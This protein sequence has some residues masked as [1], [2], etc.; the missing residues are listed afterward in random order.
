MALDPY[1]NASYQTN[2]YA[3]A[4]TNRDLIQKVLAEKQMK[5]AAYMAQQQDRYQPTGIIGGAS[6]SRPLDLAG[7]LQ[8]YDNLLGGL[9]EQLDALENR[10]SSI[11]LDYQNHTMEKDTGPD[12]TGS[13][14]TMRAYHLNSVLRN[15]AERLARVTQSVNL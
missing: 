12:P 3:D 4:Q 5:H 8:A 11:L 10:L 7:E 13:P 1:G 9:M 15:A 6:V 14:I 2:P